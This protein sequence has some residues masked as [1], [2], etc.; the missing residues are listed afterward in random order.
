VFDLDYLVFDS[1]NIKAVALRKSL[2]SL[3]DQIPLAARLPDSTD[4]LDGFLENGLHWL[5]RLEIGIGDPTELHRTYA[6]QE[7]RLLEGGA[8]RIYPGILETLQR[9]RQ[10][11]VQLSLGAETSREYLLRVSD[12]H[13]LDRQFDS[14][15]CTEEFGLGSSEEMI[16]E[17]MQHHEVQPSETIV[18]GTR[19]AYF[20]SARYLDVRSIAC[21]WG[22]S[23]QRILPGADY[24]AQTVSALWQLWQEVDEACGHGRF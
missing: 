19:P 20:E 7:A 16:Q 11:G 17:L 18:L 6:V 23:D 22:I 1:S 9:L 14:A 12:L 24:R 5:E 13:Q 21:T 4:I 8:G 2:V 10:E 15:F 3:A